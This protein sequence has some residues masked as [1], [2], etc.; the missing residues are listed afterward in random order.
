VALQAALAA[1]MTATIG[2]LPA[3]QTLTLAAPASLWLIAQYLVGD[4]PGLVLPTY[5]DLR[6][7]NDIINPAVP[8]PGPLEVLVQ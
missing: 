3:V 4:T 5:L 7:R 1:D 8:P 2:R 6:A